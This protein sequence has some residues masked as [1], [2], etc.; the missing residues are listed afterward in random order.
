MNPKASVF[1]AYAVRLR[2]GAGD[3]PRFDADVLAIGGA[4]T[5]DVAQLK[6]SVTDAIHPQAVGWWV[7]ALL[8][9]IAG[10]AVIAQALSRQAGVETE[11]Y[12]TLS[13]L[14]FGSNG[15]IELG[16]VRAFAIGCAGAVGAMLVAFALSPLAPVGEA[17]VAE[18]DTGL[19][20]DGVVL[21]LGAVTIAF[22]VLLLGLWPALRESRGVRG[23]QRILSTRSSARWASWWRPVRRRAC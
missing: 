16:L 17:R 2:H 6:T 21:G 3:L 23:D 14:G 8:A 19:A 5:S 11:T 15:L 12:R 22:V 9:A 4:G 13:A 1:D 18:P 20:F 10:L 7:L